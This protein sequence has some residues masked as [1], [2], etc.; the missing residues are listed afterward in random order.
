MAAESKLRSFFTDMD[1]RGASQNIRFR[2]FSRV[3]LDNDEEDNINTLTSRVEIGVTAFQG[4][5][6]GEFWLQ[7]QK[8]PISFKYQIQ[9]FINKVDYMRQSLFSPIELAR[10]NS[11]LH[12]EFITKFKLPF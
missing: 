8:Q 7:N 12:T 10:Y 9:D 5:K 2:P 6:E 3:E 1:I 11:K 4:E